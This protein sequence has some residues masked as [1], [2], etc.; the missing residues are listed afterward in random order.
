MPEVTIAFIPEQDDFVWKISSEKVPHMTFLFLGEIDNQD[1]IKNIVEYVEHTNNVSLRR[2]GMSVDRR[3]EL[4]DDN[5]D[6]LFFDDFNVKWLEQV[7]SHLLKNRNIWQ[8]YNSVPQFDKW[9]PHL[10]LGFPESPAKEDTRDFPGIRWVEFDR[11]AVWTGNSEGPT[12]ALK[13]NDDFELD[14][15]W[16]DKVLEFLSHHGV[17]GMKWGVRRKSGGSN[18]PRTRTSFKKSPKKLSDAELQ[19]R[20]KRME[21]E[22]RYNQLNAKDK[23]KGRQFVEE[24]LSG[25]GKKLSKTVVT[26]AGIV[27]VKSILESRLGSEFAKSVANRL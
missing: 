8:A 23:S 17:K 25:S 3:G 9:I 26:A 10:T 15:R 16:S 14:A 6:V 12:F 1:T 7:R 11:I 20:I 19:K 4:G 22:K 2:F 21:T 5:A 24:V 18:S 13:K 27:A